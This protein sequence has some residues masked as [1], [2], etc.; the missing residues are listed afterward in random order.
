MSGEHRETADDS[1]WQ[2]DQ[3]PMLRGQEQQLLSP[4]SAYRTTA[5]DVCSNPS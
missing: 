5:A 1:E 2:N 3:I 4:Q